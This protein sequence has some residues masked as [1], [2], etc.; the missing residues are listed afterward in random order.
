M[1]DVWSTQDFLRQ[2]GFHKFEKLNLTVNW[3]IS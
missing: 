3:T 1:T 2:I